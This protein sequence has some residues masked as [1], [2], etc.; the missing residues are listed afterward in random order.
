L[1]LV[2]VVAVGI[3]VLARRSKPPAVVRAPASM[4]ATPTAG[5]TR[6]G[7]PKGHE[8][9]GKLLAKTAC[10]CFHDPRLKISRWVAYRAEGDAPL[11]TQRYKGDFFPEPGLAP[12]QRAELLD[13]EGIW[14]SDQS[15]YDRGHLA[16]DGT[17]KKFGPEAQRETYSLANITPQHSAINQRV[18]SD[19][20][21]AIRSWSSTESPVWVVTGPAFFAGQETTWVGRDRVAVP[22]AYYAVINRSSAPE[23]RAYLVANTA[24]APWSSSLNRYLVSVD[25]VEK[26]TGLDFLPELPDSLENRL[27][28]ERPHAAWR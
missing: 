16:P 27:E 4:P 12:G 1:V 24:E 7:L 2:I 8:S 25:S 15:G 11:G 10:E 18:W 13:Y 23:V 6:F 14:K 28:R 22:H 5:L 26:L 21:A 17:I 3:A 20:E 9:E 19:L